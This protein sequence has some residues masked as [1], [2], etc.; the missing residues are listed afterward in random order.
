[1]IKELIEDKTKLEENILELL[2][3]FQEKYPKIIFKDIHLI[4]K[5]ERKLNGEIATNELINVILDLEISGGNR[6]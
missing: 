6:K 4:H 3:K 1:M 2:K 5:L